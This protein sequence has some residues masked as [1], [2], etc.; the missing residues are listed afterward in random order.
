MS[1]RSIDHDYVDGEFEPKKES[2]ITLDQS[3]RYLLLKVDYERQLEKLSLKCDAERQQR[4]MA[5]AELEKALVSRRII[6]HGYYEPRM[7]SFH[8]NR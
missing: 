5:E 7:I 6:V 8:G 3:E 4:L 1:G 2:S